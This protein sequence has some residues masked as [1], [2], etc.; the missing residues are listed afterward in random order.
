V[1]ETSYSDTHVPGQD[2]GV[3]GVV[4]EE[5]EGPLD[6]TPGAVAWTIT[7]FILGSWMWVVGQ[8]VGSLSCTG[9]GYWVVFDSFGVGLR[10]VIPGWLEMGGKSERERLKRSYG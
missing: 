8:Q 4:G 6:S 9:V 3:V 7:Q 10:N 1:T 2:V 5:E